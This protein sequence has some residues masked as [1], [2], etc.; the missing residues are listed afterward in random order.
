MSDIIHAMPS[1]DRR[2]LSII[3]D[4]YMPCFPMDLVDLGSDTEDLCFLDDWSIEEA[5]DGEG[6]LCVDGDG[7]PLDRIDECGSP[8]GETPEGDP[9]FTDETDAEDALNERRQLRDSERHGFPWANSYVF[10][11]ADNVST[12]ELIRHG[13]VVAETATSYRIAGI[14]GG[15]YSF[16][17]AHFHPLA[18]ALAERWGMTIRYDDGTV[19]IHPERL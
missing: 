15:G 14:D 10:L 9:Y 16:T 17:D 3:F 1:D 18:L 6:F 5:A 11:P 2:R 7:D 13:F 8:D 19:G 4:R 12:E